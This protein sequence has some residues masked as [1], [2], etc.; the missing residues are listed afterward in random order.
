MRTEVIL[1]AL[2]VCG[3]LLALWL[4]ARRHQRL[5]VLRA[6]R[7]RLKL[8][9]GRMPPLLFDEFEDIVRRARLDGVTV[10]VLVEDGEPRLY[11]DG[12][13][14]GVEQSLRNVLGR[15]PLTRIRT[16]TRR[17]RSG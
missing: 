8:V 6:E 16:G 11:V 14:Q 12:P 15:F 2:V 1:V 10:R 5:F 3:F 9:A 7:G 17:A 4:A 13:G